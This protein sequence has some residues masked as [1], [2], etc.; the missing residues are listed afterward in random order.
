MGL[1]P[2]G[3]GF[4][5]QLRS[6]LHDVHIGCMHAKAAQQLLWAQPTQFLF[7]GLAFSASELYLSLQNWHTS[8]IGC[9]F[10]LHAAW[11]CDDADDTAADVDGVANASDDCGVR[12]TDDD[13]DL[14]GWR[15]VLMLTLVLEDM[16]IMMCRWRTCLSANRPNLLHN[17]SWNNIKQI[18]R[19]IEQCVS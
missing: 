6:G 16:V 7:L 9:L 10:Y 11:V 4:V 14:M 8:D 2:L 18:V 17:G 1:L 13:G 15:V 19:N 12:N 3:Q 5:T